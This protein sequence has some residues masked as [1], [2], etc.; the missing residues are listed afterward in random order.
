MGVK[1]IIAALGLITVLLT[2]ISVWS[3]DWS[4][5]YEKVREQHVVGL[6]IETNGLCTGVVVK[7][8][9]VLTAAH[10]VIPQFPDGALAQSVQIVDTFGQK[11]SATVLK[12]NVDL[13]LALLIGNTPNKFPII[14][15]NVSPNV[16]T[17][18]AALGYHTNT[19]RP[20]MTVSHIM[21]KFPALI[22]VDNLHQFGYSGGPLINL[23]GE[24]VGINVQ[25]IPRDG[26]G[27]SMSIE[28]VR[29]FLGN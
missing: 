3:F 17:E 16:G 18:V 14:L 2:P 11:T 12:A 27:V 15:A 10:C 23:A 26:A 8:S 6:Q 25:Q 21:Q 28:I 5:I 22:L 29:W 20:D 24:L 1:T 7:A 19:L 13:D 4:G 9:T